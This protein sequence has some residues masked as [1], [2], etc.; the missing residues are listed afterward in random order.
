MKATII[1]LLTALLG[2]TQTQ[3]PKNNPNGV[4]ESTSGT[5]YELRLNGTDLMVKLIPGSNPRYSVYEVE[6][7]NAKEDVNTY[8]GKGFFVAKVKEDKEC[9]FDTEWQLT[10]VT[11][12][13]I[14]GATSN[15]IP[16]PETCTVKEKNL[17]QLDLKKKK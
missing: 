16:D 1:F 9:K 15:I 13:R 3:M 4:W 10:V 11:L 8:V 2:Q 17:I 12:D 5:Q 7:K 6:L 14:L